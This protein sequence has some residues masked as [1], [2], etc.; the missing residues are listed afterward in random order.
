MHAS[1]RHVVVLLNVVLLASAAPV[2]AGPLQG[3]KSTDAS[4]NAPAAARAGAAQRLDP[5]P[6]SVP[7]ATSPIHTDPHPS[8]SA[9]AAEILKEA[10]VEATLTAQPRVQRQASGQAVDASAK[11]TSRDQANVGDDPLGLRQFGK[12]TV[13]WIK[14]TLPWLRSDESDSATD[15][16]RAVY[17]STTLLNGDAPRSGAQPVSLAPPGTTGGGTFDRALSVGGAHAQTTTLF[18]PEE[19]LLRRAL[20]AVGEVLGHPMT[21]LVISL[22]VIGGI[23]AKKIDRRPTK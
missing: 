7:L 14:D 19:N 13:L 21:W 23:V 11:P 5:S 16:T 12:D 18:A 15:R 17:W 8:A 2:R 1:S 4:V 20:Q 3:S 22:F 10:E 6:V 9:L